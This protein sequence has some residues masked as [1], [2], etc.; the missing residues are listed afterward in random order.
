MTTPQYLLQGRE[1]FVILDYPYRLKKLHYYLYGNS[2][3]SS[4]KVL[5]PNF[6][7]IK[8]ASFKHMTVDP[9]EIKVHIHEVGVKS[10]KRFQILVFS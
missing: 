5:I 3:I 9:I 10:R 7:P 4:V 1:A 8:V 6:V 2:V